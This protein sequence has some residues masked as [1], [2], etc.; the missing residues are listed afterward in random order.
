MPK[1][2]PKP[3]RSRGR[4]RSPTTRTTDGGNARSVRKTTNVTPIPFEEAAD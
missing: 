1:S 2:K 4:S 3:N